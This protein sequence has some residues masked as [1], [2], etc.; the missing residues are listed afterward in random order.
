MTYIFFYENYDI[1][2]TEQ[3]CANLY[4][5]MEM[6]FIARKINAT[7]VLPNFYFTPRNNELINIKNELIIDRIELI[8]LENIIDTKQIHKICKCI[9]LTDYFKLKHKNTIL[10]SKEDDNIPINNKM[11]FTIY[12][13]LKYDTE[14]KIK[15]SSLNILNY[16]VNLENY[17]NVII[18]N[19]NRMGNPIWYHKFL[20][21]YKIIRKS[22]KFQ[23][24]YYNTIDIK[25]TLMVHWRRGDFKLDIADEGETKQYYKKYNELNKIDNLLK[26]IIYRCLENTIDNVFLITN[27]NDE[28]QLNKISSILIDFN[29]ELKVYKS[30]NDNNNLNYLFADISGLIIGSKCKYQLHGYG[31]FD[32]MSQYGRWMI[33]ERQNIEDST[34]IYFIE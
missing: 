9:S 15:Y 2:K 16:L 19:Y 34:Q 8:D 29:I 6:I 18:H 14:D 32:R 31:T 25:N 28:D 1:Y 10:I 20:D 4:R 33:E 30:I 24:K 13:I 26:N 17:D 5:L 21:D 11:Y 7:L 3:L 27:E 12:G 23:D 22:I